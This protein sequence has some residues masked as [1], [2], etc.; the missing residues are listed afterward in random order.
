MIFFLRQW[1]KLYQLVSGTFYNENQDVIKKKL[2]GVQKEIQDG[3]STFNKP[4]TDANAKL[5]K[6]L[7]DKKQEKLIPFTQKLYQ[8]LD[9]DVTQSYDILCYYL[10]NEYRGSASSLQNFMSSESLMIKLLSDI[11]FYYSLERMVLLK[12]TKCIIEYHNSD[13]HPYADAFKTVL[14]QIGFGSLRKSYIDQFEALVKDIQQTKLLLGDIFNNPQKAQ[15]WSERKHREINEVLQIII[16]TCHFD[17]IKPA[18][19]KKLVELFKLHSFGK[20]NQFLSPTNEYHNELVRKV[21]YN[22]IA[23]LTV[24]LSTTNLES[25]GWM[26]EI[27]NELDEQLSSMHHY[28]EHGPILMS[29]MLFKFASKSNETTTDHYGTYG[30]LGSRAVQL[31]VFDF[32]HKMLTHRMLKDESLVSKIITRCIYDNLSFLCELFNADGSMQNHPKIFELFSEVLKSPIIARD[33][34]KSEENPIRTLF[35]SAVEK[36]PFEFI[37]LSL[38]AKSLASAS[39]LSCKW[40][41]DL[42]QNLEIYTEQPNDPIYELRKINSNDSDDDDAYE[43]VIDYQPYKKIDNFMIAAGTRAV[44]REVKGRMF[45]H[46]ITKLNYFNALHNEI[47]EM[48]SSIMN[49]SEIRES[50]VQRLEAGISFLA[51]TIKRIDDPSGITNEM[52][53]PTEMVFDILSKFKTMQEPSLDLMAKCLDVCAELIGSFG[54]EIFRRFIN[55]HIAPSVNVIHQDFRSY[56]NGIGY[57]SGLVGFYLINIERVSGRYS[58]LKSYL[59]FLKSYT[60]VRRLCLLSKIHIFILIVILAID[61]QHLLS[62]AARITVSVA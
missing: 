42:V 36:F 34:C 18:E 59:N 15:L 28:P 4:S 13:E 31:N 19:L 35:N 8:F 46:F 54:D 32:L 56:A 24:A 6:M 48:M 3:L 27:V 20:H 33:F 23:L 1:K 53:H 50:R 39:K 44:V 60:K 21:T 62:R 43:L 25:I 58:F 9:L 30:K 16:M 40:I 49:Y 57:K 10:V 55:L 2:L 12:V 51:A 37:P 47:N 38:I 52:I 61:G 11:W 17:R 14:D 5:E 41:L 22:E 29:W 7:K 26:E 45:V